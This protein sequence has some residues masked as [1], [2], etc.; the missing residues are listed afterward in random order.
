MNLTKLFLFSS[1]LTKTKDLILKLTKLCSIR[2]D[3]VYDEFKSKWANS[4]LKGSLAKNQSQIH[5]YQGAK[6]DNNSFHDIIDYLKEEFYQSKQNV[7]EMH[8]Y[9]VEKCLENDKDMH[10]VAS[11]SMVSNAFL[12]WKNQMINANKR[13]NTEHLVANCK[14]NIC[15]CKTNDILIRD[16]FSLVIRRNIKLLGSFNKIYNFTSNYVNLLEPITQNHISK[17]NYSDQAIL[18]GE[19]NLQDKFNLED[20]VVPLMLLDKYSSIDEIIKKDERTLLNV[21]EICDRLCASEL[22]LKEFASKYTE[23]KHKKFDKFKAKSIAKYAS[24]CLKRHKKLNLISTKYINIAFQLKLSQ[25]RFLCNLKYDNT[26]SDP[27]SFDAWSELVIDLIGTDETLQLKLLLELIQFR[28]DVEVAYKFLCVFGYEK[29]IQRLSESHREFVEQNLKFIETSK[30]INLI[31]NEAYYYP[32]ELI[33]SIRFVQ[34][35]DEW[36]QMLDYFENEKPNVIGLDCE[37]KPSFDLADKEDEQTRNRSSTFQI[38]TH[39]CAFVL[40]MKDLISSLEESELNRFGNLIL[41]NEDIVKLGYS[42]KQDANKLAISFPK[43]RHR[44]SE[45]EESVIN[46]DEIVNLILKK[47]DL[48]EKDETANGSKVKT[49]KQ[50]KGLSELTRKCF[51]KPLNKS[52]CISNWDARPLR[53]AQIRYAALD[54][55][56]LIQI[57]EFI[58]N[59]IKSLGVNID[60]TAKKLFC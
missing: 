35:R 41:F 52:E 54:A 18:I 50:S 9:L 4:L 14:D 28:K 8:L 33:N 55:Y 58:Q 48:F 60:Y 3:T 59:K 46:L 49:A 34:T 1:N 45:F 19:L 43:F 7:F 37:W 27:I 29:M 51:G 57:H 25:M 56:V 17:L 12:E 31:P 11:A 21:I 24:T 53:E 42:F 39:T 36:N 10:R 40:D 23:L 2:M 47:C 38:A 16:A 32:V 13:K 30:E 44:F 15:V 20:I 22:N 26:Y 5:S 6:L